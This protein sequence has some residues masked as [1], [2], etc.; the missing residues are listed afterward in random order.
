MPT[1]KRRVIY[2]SDVEWDQVKRRAERAGVSASE[3][4]RDLVAAGAATQPGF[5]HSRA[6]PKPSKS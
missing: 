3:F 4:L 1:Q 2:L 5:G 6:A